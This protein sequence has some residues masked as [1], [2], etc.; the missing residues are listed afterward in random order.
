MNTRQIQQQM[1]KDQQKQDQKVAAQD[2]AHQDMLIEEQ[3]EEILKL[4]QDV[5]V[6]NEMFGDMATLVNKQSGYVDNITTNIANTSNNIK[7]VNKNLE[8]AEKLQNMFS[9]RII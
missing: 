4:Y 5:K 9:C 2:I 6:V 3:H 8:S 1:S 7:G